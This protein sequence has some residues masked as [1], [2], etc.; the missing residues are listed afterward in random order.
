MDRVGVDFVFAGHEK[1][2]EG[3][4]EEDPNL[5]SIERNGPTCLKFGAC[6]VGVLR[7]SGGC[8]EG[9]WRVLDGVWRV[10]GGCLKGI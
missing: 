7:V 6:L 3:R 10:G 8:L 4:K 5:A 1:E 9:V 2:E